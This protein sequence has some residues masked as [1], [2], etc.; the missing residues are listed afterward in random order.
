MWV[1]KRGA[2]NAPDGF[3]EYWDICLRCSNYD[4]SR[5]YHCRI[6]PQTHSK[7]D[8]GGRACGPTGCHSFGRLFHQH[9]RFLLVDGI[10]IF[11]LLG[12]PHAVQ[13]TA[14][15]TPH[16]IPC[17]FVSGKNMGGLN[18]LRPPY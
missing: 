2:R 3:G 1:P 14:R 5:F 15:C 18:C 13:F 6:Q 12:N 4:Y 7:M 9:M 17:T 11:A 8:F 10:Q 16:T